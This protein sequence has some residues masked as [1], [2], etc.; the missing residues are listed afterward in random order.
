M[1]WVRLDDAFLDH[2]KFL[3]VGPVAG[4]MAVTALAWS[5]RNLTDGFI[6]GAQVNRLVD[7]EGIVDELHFGNGH[8]TA[9]Q[10]AEL[11]VGARLWETAPRGYVIHDYTQFQLT[12]EQIRHQRQKTAVRVSQ[13]RQRNAV[14]NPVTNGGV[15]GAPN[16]N[17][18]TKPPIAPQGGR[19]RDLQRFNTAVVA[20][21]AEQFP[22]L[23][24]EPA[25]QAVSQACRNGHAQTRQDVR[26]WMTR[27]FPELAYQLD[28]EEGPS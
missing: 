20:Y 15:T 25:R 26:A 12:A 3:E 23:P 1:S 10:I 5:N 11:L 14:T 17:P 16:P 9:L 28:Q 18:N 24:A 22:T 4:F 21:A 6:P 2:P 7:L 8:V 19:K 27:W 13:W